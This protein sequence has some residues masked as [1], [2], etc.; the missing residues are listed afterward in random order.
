MKG[1]QVGMIHSY[2]GK[3]RGERSW[4]VV[5]SIGVAAACMM[6]CLN[7]SS[8]LAVPM[9]NDPGGFLEFPWGSS[10]EGRP[11]VAPVEGGGRVKEYILVRTPLRLGN[12]PVSSIR[13]VA[14]NG[15]FSRAVVRY[16]GYDTHTALVAS[17][18]RWFGALDLTPGQLAAGEEQTLNW[19]GPDTE[20]NLTF[21]VRRGQGVLFVESRALASQ[22]NED[23]GGQ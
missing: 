10:L 23:M 17:L 4:G 13:L 18:Q 22:F 16:E 12:V 19:R 9:T 11:D 3:G 21:K 20:M 6:T 8:L 7:P 15:K 2:A 14:I 5:L 1:E